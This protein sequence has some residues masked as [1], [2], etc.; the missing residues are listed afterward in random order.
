MKLFLI[1][2]ISVVLLVYI[3]ISLY[4]FFKQ[5]SM[6]FFP[7]SDWE[8]TPSDIDIYWEEFK[9]K[10]PDNELISAWF[11]PCSSDTN[12]PNSLNNEANSDIATSCIIFSHGN[13]GNI[14]HRLET[15]KLIHNLGYNLLIYDYR[16]YGK[17]TGEIKTAGTYTDVIT[18]YDFL[19]KEKGFE[20]IVSHGRSLGAAM[21]SKLAKERL[22]VGLVLESAFT[23][24]GNLAAEDYPYLPIKLLLLHNYKTLHDAKESSC[25]ALV[26]HSPE[27]LMIPFN[28]G[29][30]IANQLG[31]RA[32]LLEITGDHN[33]GFL[34]S[35]KKYSDALGKF[36]LSC[37]K[38]K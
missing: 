28:H 13:G 17:S 8:Q 35:G 5:K 37:F 25:R 10:T 31:L 34:V 29:Q 24:L 21:A 16:G 32:E 7:Y 19:T 2:L 22:C 36:Y 18:V 27:D 15:I 4:F 6:I 20:K 3:C 38:S 30:V 14:S 23:S 11:I 9:I 33:D 1:I 26:I 12:S